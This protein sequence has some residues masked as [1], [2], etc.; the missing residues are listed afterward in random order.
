[1]LPKTKLR[2]SQCEKNITI[3]KICLMTVFF[4]LFKITYPRRVYE[5]GE[6]QREIFEEGEKSL[7]KT[8]RSLV[9]LIF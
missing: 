2:K 7:Q 4:A 8:V 3:T 1:M 6:H 5:R 9:V